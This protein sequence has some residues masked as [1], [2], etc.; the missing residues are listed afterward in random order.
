MDPLPSLVR[1]TALFP[2]QR[3]AED[4]YLVSFEARWLRA[5]VLSVAKVENLATLVCIVFYSKA[6]PSLARSD[7]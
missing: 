1:D 2:P 6:R 4:E 5:E 3:D 7:P